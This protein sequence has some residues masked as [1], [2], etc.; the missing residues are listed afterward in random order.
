MRESFA[1]ERRRR[2]AGGGARI[3]GGQ[4]G[5]RAAVPPQTQQKT[6]PPLP[7]PNLHATASAKCPVSR[8][9]AAAFLPHVN[10]PYHSVNVN[11]VNLGLKNFFAAEYDQW[12]TS[13]AADSMS[14]LGSAPGQASVVFE[15]SA[16]N[17]RSLLRRRPIF[18][19]RRHRLYLARTLKPMAGGAR[20]KPL[21]L[22]IGSCGAV[23]RTAKYDRRWAAFAIRRAQ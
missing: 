7:R 18:A 4:R 15:P 1:R 13:P 19:D 9:N 22:A 21:R 2:F 11:S 3:R 14:R 10:L 17:L 6:H 8:R 12:L 23:Q 5:Q 16:V 20:L